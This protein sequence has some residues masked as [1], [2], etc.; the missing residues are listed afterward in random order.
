M[1]MFLFSENTVFSKTMHKSEL[2][3][4]AVWRAQVDDLIRHFNGHRQRKLPE[5]REMEQMKASY[6]NS[7]P[8]LE[9][10]HSSTRPGAAVL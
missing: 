9:T 4:S 5:E 7:V 2:I 8:Y 1:N 6:N 3:T 10:I